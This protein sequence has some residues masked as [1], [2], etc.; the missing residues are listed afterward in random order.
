MKVGINP[1]SSFIHRLV[2]VIMGINARGFFK[3]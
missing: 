1:G 3:K 2:K